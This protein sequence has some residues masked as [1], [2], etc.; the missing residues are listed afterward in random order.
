MKPAP[1]VIKCVMVLFVVSN[2]ATASRRSGAWVVA[3]RFRSFQTEQGLI[4]GSSQGQ[5]QL[6]QNKLGS[7]GETPAKGFCDPGVLPGQPRNFQCPAHTR[8]ELLGLLDNVRPFGIEIDQPPLQVF[9]TRGSDPL[10]FLQRTKIT[11]VQSHRDEL[12]LHFSVGPPN[13][14]QPTGA[15]DPIKEFG[16]RNEAHAKLL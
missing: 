16:V 13:M 11:D 14:T 2:M 6:R 9:Q 1:P 8:R 7:L 3:E 5:P 4:Q 15:D 10:A 12:R